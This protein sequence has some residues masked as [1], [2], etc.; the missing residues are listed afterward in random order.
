M[1]RS[2]CCKRFTRTPEQV[3]TDTL[4]AQYDNYLKEPGVA[5]EKRYADLGRGE[6]RSR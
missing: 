3:A 6:T 5:P 4:R 2:R 1:K